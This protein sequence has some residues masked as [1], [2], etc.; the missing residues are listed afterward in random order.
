VIFQKGDIVKFMLSD[1][2]GFGKRDLIYVYGLFDYFSVKSTK[3]L[4]RKIWD[5][6]APGGEIIFTNAHPNNPT[7]LWMNYIG[8]WNLDY[9][10]K[11]ELL[12]ISEGLEGVKNVD[13]FMDELDVYQYMRIQ[14]E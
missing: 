4:V 11:E 6:L 12:S 13:Y 5:S 10:C 2:E 7:K 8:E 9:K 1:K 14:R 3:R